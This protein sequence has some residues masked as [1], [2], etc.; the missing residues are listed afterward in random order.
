MSD[1]LNAPEGA[2]ELNDLELEAVAS[3]KINV[4]G[5]R[6]GRGRGGGWG[7][8]WGGGFG[9]ARGFWW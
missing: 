2:T 1:H 6:W 5:G 4:G 8:G 7:G 9:F 3:G